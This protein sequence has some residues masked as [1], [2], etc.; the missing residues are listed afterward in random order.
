VLRENADRTAA[1]SA[2]EQAQRP[3]AAA[4]QGSV[5]AGADLLIPA[6]AEAIDDRNARL[7]GHG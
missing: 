6:T 4:A 5:T 1:F 7:A 2:Y 3:Y